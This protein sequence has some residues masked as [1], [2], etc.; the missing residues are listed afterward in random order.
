MI[1]EECKQAVIINTHKMGDKNK[2][3]NYREMSY[4]LNSAC[5]IHVTVS[6]AK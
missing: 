5:T 2:G 3:T 6:K 1:P 4:L